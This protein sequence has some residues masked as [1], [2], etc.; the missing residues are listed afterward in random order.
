MNPNAKCLPLDREL[1]SN[2]K[3]NI[4]ITQCL[5]SSGTKDMHTRQR[6][7]DSW[8]MK[9]MYVITVKPYLISRWNTRN[10]AEEQASLSQS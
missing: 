5:T 10:A 7:S 3:G 9:K 8:P 6:W 1:A 2:A 4:S